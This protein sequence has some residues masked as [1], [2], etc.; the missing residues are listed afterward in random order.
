MLYNRDWQGA[1]DAIVHPQDG[2]PPIS[3]TCAEE[4]TGYSP[5]R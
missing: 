2:F 3:F 5:F 1:G 4:F